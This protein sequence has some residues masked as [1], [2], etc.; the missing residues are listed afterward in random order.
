MKLTVLSV[1]MVAITLSWGPRGLLFSDSEGESA[2]A[3]KYIPMQVAPKEVQKQYAAMMTKCILNEGIEKYE[4]EECLFITNPSN[5]IIICISNK[6][7]YESLFKMV[8]M[9]VN[10]VKRVS[11]NK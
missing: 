11:E 7:M 3:A 6:L 8:L 1:V 4:G 10:A 9:F 2:P 5:Q